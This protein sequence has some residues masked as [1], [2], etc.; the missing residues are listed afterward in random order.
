MSKIIFL[1]GCASAGKTTLA[2]AIQYCSEEPYLFVGIDAL[3]S[4]LPK[5]LVGFSEKNEKEG[6]RYV[7]NPET[8]VLTEMRVSPYAGKVFSCLP[9]VIKL[10]ADNGL[11]I[12]FDEC[13]FHYE[14]VENYK[15][16][17]SN[18]KFFS[19]GVKCDLETMEEREKLRSNR[20]IGMAKIFH[21]SAKNFRYPYDL[22]VDTANNSP[23]TNAK[24]VLNFVEDSFS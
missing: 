17:F 12:I 13:N 15:I 2:K 9:K 3:F 6:F 16:F 21:Q 8:G 10:L 22:I 23:F 11:N 18:H 24:K 19:I 4:A 5:K 7:V 14:L 20:V 1:N